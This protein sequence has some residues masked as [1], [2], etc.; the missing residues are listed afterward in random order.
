[1]ASHLATH[2]STV[3]LGLLF[4]LPG[5]VKTVRLNTTLYREMLKTFKNFTEVSPLRHIG[6]IPSPQIYMQSMGVFELL[7]GTTLVVGHVSF[8]KFA[9]LGIMALMLLTTYCQVALKDYSAVRTE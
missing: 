6:V 1:M 3:V 2:V 5:I 4:I 7:L 8:K 9:C